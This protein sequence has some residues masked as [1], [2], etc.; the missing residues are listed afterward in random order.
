LPH[1]PRRKTTSQVLGRNPSEVRFSAHNCRKI[2][3]EHKMKVLKVKSLFR[4]WFCGSFDAAAAA[5]YAVTLLSR[6]KS[7]NII[8]EKGI[9]VTVLAVFLVLADW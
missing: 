6:R 9:F 2:F 8:I 7:S 4:R 5:S 3:V 1:S